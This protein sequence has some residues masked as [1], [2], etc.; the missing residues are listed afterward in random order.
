MDSV[1]SVLEARLTVTRLENAEE[2]L[3]ESES[4][5]WSIEF[6]EL[7]RS[8]NEGLYDLHEDKEIETDPAEILTAVDNFDYGKA[9]GLLSKEE[10]YNGFYDQPPEH[11]TTSIL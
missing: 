5:R 8:L 2:K 3:Q 4:R 10:D 6:T 9:R 1:D 11:R 7:Y